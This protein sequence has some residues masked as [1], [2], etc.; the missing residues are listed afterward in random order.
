MQFG[1]SVTGGH[2][3]YDSSPQAFVRMLHERI[4]WVRAARDAGF[5]S[6]SMGQHVLGHPPRH[7]L[8]QIMPML[9]RFTAEAPGMRMMTSILIGPLYNPAML[10]EEVSTLDGL[11]DGK[12]TLVLGLGY[13]EEE[14][15]TFNTTKRERVPRAEELAQV[16]KLL[17]TQER[18]D[19][20]G[21]FFHVH[22]PGLVHRIVAKPHPRLWFGTGSDA[23][24]RR[25]ARLGDGVYQGQFAPLR[26]LERQLGLYR[27]ALAAEGKPASSGSFSICREVYLGES[28]AKV[29]AEA[30]PGFQRTLAAYKK[31]GV[32]DTMLPGF[33]VNAGP[34][35]SPE[36]LPFLMG[37]PEEC[38]EQLTMYRDRL[39]LKFVNLG[40]TSSGIPHEQV[41]ANIRTF[42]EKV[43]PK[44]R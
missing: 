24:M 16:I 28:R 32:E 11:T 41:L 22:G 2:Y 10:A 6:V 13:R 26:D 18:V 5:S 44:F 37:N 23:G 12:F 15:L 25:A 19:F 1:I 42:G 31:A 30:L 40:F 36:E 27:A 33:L 34:D 39:G 21:R 14:F 17:W 4:E 38:V 35:S 9:A 8:P 43:L 29:V 7:M 20:D 3:N